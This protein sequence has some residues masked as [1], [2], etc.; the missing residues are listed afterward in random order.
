[1]QIL[2]NRKLSMIRIQVL[3]KLQEAGDFYP[4]KTSASHLKQFSKPT[5]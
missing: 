5:D 3:I 2:C 1:M 4:T